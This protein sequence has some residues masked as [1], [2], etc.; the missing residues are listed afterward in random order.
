MRTALAAICLEQKE[1]ENPGMQLRYSKPNLRLS[2]VPLCHVHFV[3]EDGHTVWV[4]E[5][6]E[7]AQVPTI[8]VEHLDA[9][10]VEIRA[11]TS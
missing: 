10:V 1:F 5:R 3:I 4:I 2:G 9:V 11:Y 8:A 7:L 6:I